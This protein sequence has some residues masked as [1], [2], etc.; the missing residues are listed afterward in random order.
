M[1]KGVFYGISVGP[2]DAELLTLKAV[3]TIEKLQVIATPR[4]KGENT[5]ALDIVSQEVDLAGK[6]ILML[7][8][9]MTRDKVK[10]KQRHCEIAN[11]IKLKLDVGIDVGM[12]NLGDVSVYSTFSYIMDILLENNYP[13]EIIPGVTSFC[14]V[15]AKLQQSLTT[16]NEPLHILPGNNVAEGLKLEGTKVIMKSV[17]NIDNVKKAIYD[18]GLENNVKAVQ[19]CG[20]PN[21]KICNSLDDIS[22]ELGY[23]T[24]IVVK[25]ISKK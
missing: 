11:E 2:G 15:A 19:N 5:L 21:E 13:V 16:M 24:T 9:L 20:L 4:T 18:N 8:F 1:K 23:F 25:G 6:E 7:D 10:L 22:D 14:S 17:R 12:L 3:R